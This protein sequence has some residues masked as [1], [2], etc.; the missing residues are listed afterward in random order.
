MSHPSVRP[1]SSFLYVF[2][3]GSRKVSGAVARGV[4]RSE[5]TR[6]TAGDGP[7]AGT[8]LY[9]ADSPGATKKLLRPNIFGEHL[10]RTCAPVKR[11]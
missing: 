5:T 9:R 11:P 10:P 8:L 7:N 4:E 6:A 2:P 1:R 3:R